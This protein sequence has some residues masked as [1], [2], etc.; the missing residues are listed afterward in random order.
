MKSHIPR[1]LC[2]LTL[3]LNRA[4]A[5]TKESVAGAP[6]I[7]NTRVVPGRYILELSST[8]ISARDEDYSESSSPA[9]V[10]KIQDL[11]YAVEI[12]EDFSATS[13]RFLGVSINIQNDNSSTLSDLRTIPEVTNAWPVEPITLDVDFDTGNPSRKWNP[14]ISTRVDE[15]HQKGFNG[16]GQRVCVVDT[17]VDRE[18]PAF[19][20]R[21]AGG[22]N[23]IT[24]DE[25]LED[26]VG[27]GTFVSS[28]IVGQN[29]DF[30]GV[31]PGAEVFM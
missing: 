12:K 3:L 27:H 31:A 6:G 29:K 4:H 22:K 11:G 5:W 20:G 14:H 10:A 28:I 24:D 23:M 30:V 21:I 7:S 16:A 1:T 25:N 15:L 18:H 9:V 13:A 26:C 19:N 2:I 17:G 8:A